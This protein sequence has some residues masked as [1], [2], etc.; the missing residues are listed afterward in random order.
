MIIRER[1]LV[2]H[3]SIVGCESKLGRGR[4]WRDPVYLR[5]YVST[6]PVH[7]WGTCTVTLAQFLA[8]AA[9]PPTILISGYSRNELIVS[10]ANTHAWCV[11]CNRNMLVLFAYSRHFSW[12][13]WLSFCQRIAIVI[14]LYEN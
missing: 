10:L 4:A 7:T 12:Y 9:V 5:K 11:V 1:I 13:S 6:W 8:A 14:D 3:W 2:D